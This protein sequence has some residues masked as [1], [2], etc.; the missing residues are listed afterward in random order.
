M[1]TSIIKRLRKNAGITQKN[2]AS[3]CGVAQ[4]TVS[5]WENGVA[6]PTREHTRRLAEI[7]GMAFESLDKKILEQEKGV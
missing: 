7:F 2:L 3:L 1:I 6:T 5:Q 4:N